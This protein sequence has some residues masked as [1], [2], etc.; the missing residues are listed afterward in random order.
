MKNH[1]NALNFIFITLLIDVIGLGIIIPVVP[2]LLKEITGSEVSEAS[3]INGWLTFAYATMQFAFSPVLGALSDK[4]GRRPILLLSLL[5]LGVDY[6][7]QGFA[8]NLFWLFIGRMIAG[9][10]GASYSTCTAY[11]A[12][13][14]EPEKRAQNFGIVGIAFGVGFIIGPI[15]GGICGDIWGPRAPFYVA[16][17]FSLI[18]LV[19]GYFVLPESLSKENRRNFEWKRAN[20][21]GAFKQLKKYSL[22]MP[23]VIAEF[24]VYLAGK[25]VESNWTFFTKYKF[26]WSDTTMGLSL[27]FVGILIALVQG[28]LIR[29]VIPKFG[30]KKAVIVG[31]VL[32]TL[33]LF[34]FSLAS[35]SWMM[36]AFLIP[37][38]LGGIA[39]P[40]LQGVISN[41]VPN[42]EQGELQGAINS[43]VSITYIVGPLMMNSLFYYFTKPD[44]PFIFPG[45]PFLLGT[46]FGLIGLV[47]AY[48][49]MKGKA[50]V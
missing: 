16:G 1:K 50:I 43:A 47:L 41:Q 37:Y 20:P 5:G 48:R 7:V 6:F 13:I 10:S 29:I 30:S 17:I 14:S 11:I 15:I 27:G 35:S 28:W 31:L 26:N 24:F 36:F 49:A 44:A 3:S 46:F 19:Y 2:E 4:F 38:C 25:A 18:N 8:P 33:G 12:D 21:F 23:L 32:D 34:L 42:D 22:V 45:A 39:G 40:A 9:F